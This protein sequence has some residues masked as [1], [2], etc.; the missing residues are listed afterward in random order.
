MKIRK[1]SVNQGE[2]VWEGRGVGRAQAEGGAGLPRYGLERWEWPRT[3][4]T[5]LG[6][7]GMTGWTPSLPF[8]DFFNMIKCVMRETALCI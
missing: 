1:E 2:S 7:A 8:D 6:R 5:R 4:F 3:A